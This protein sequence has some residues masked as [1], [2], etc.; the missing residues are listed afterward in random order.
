MREHQ[1][2]ESALNRWVK[3]PGG[4]KKMPKVKKHSSKPKVKKAKA[5]KHSSEP[6][7][8]KAKTKKPR[9]K[10]HK[11]HKIKNF[12]LS[13]DDHK[14]NTISKFRDKEDMSEAT[15][16][17]WKSGQCLLDDNQ[18]QA[19]QSTIQFLKQLD[20]S[21]INFANY[22]HNKALRLLLTTMQQGLN[23]FPETCLPNVTYWNGISNYCINSHIAFVITLLMT[24][25]GTNISHWKDTHAEVLF[26]LSN[27]VSRLKGSSSGDNQTMLA[28]S[29]I[30]RDSDGD[31]KRSL[32]WK[33]NHS[34]MPIR[35]TGTQ[36]TEGTN[37]WGYG[38]KLE[39]MGEQI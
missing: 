31:W 12:D 38:S 9:P 2:P 35:V 7:A 20:L 8:K 4:R 15:P 33:L 16:E 19:L 5:K 36:F 21:T 23:E 17:D 14:V 27:A 18:H 1:L 22:I 25:R 10:K 30:F 26:A 13:G 29:K 28:I 34:R 39:T 6:K 24:I 3:E 32:D 11:K 37:A